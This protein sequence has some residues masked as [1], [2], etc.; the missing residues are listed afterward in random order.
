MKLLEVLKL[1]LLSDLRHYPQ[2]WLGLVG[3]TLAER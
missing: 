1:P 3:S 2:E